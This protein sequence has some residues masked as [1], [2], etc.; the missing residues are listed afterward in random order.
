MK[1]RKTILLSVMLIS[2]ATAMICATLLITHKVSHNMNRQNAASN[3]SQKG[4]EAINNSGSTTSTSKIIVK[5]AKTKMKTVEPAKKETKNKTTASIEPKSSMT[6]TD[7]NVKNVETK[8]PSQSSPAHNS[9]NSYVTKSE[10]KAIEK[11]VD[12]NPSYLKTISKD[13]KDIKVDQLTIGDDKY[14]VGNN[15][16]LITTHKNGDKDFTSLSSESDWALFQANNSLN[17]NDYIKLVK[18]YNTVNNYLVK[19]K[20]TLIE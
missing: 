14:M 11:Q 5:R 4:A 12:D 3:I 15:Q 18:Y 13:P 8:I 16:V 10:V 9:K 2:F 1:N 6:L 19:Y 20:I 7:G 17:N